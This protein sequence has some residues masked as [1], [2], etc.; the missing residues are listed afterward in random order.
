[1]VLRTVNNGKNKKNAQS[2]FLSEGAA[3]LICIMRRGN[4]REDFRTDNQRNHLQRQVRRT[5]GEISQ[6]F[7]E[8]K[9]SSTPA[10]N[11]HRLKA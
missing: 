5:N 3:N 9:T 4:G 8:N 10:F 1:M 6:M 11:E 2:A 7:A